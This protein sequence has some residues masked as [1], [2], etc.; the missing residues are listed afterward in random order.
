MDRI[1]NDTS[2]NS[3]IVACVFVT[4]VMFYIT[5]LPSNERRNKR[6]DIDEWAGF[7]KYTV[8]TGSGAIIYILGLIKIGSDIPKLIG[9]EIHRHADSMIS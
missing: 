8:D 2:N 5:L 3:S 4:A 9:V 7:M 1:E 6:I